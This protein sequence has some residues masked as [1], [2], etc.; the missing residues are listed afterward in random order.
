MSAQGAQVEESHGN[1]NN[2]KYDD[3]DYDNDDFNNE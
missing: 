3:D 1:S 2:R